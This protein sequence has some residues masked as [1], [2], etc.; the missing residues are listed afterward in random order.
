MDKSAI[1]NQVREFY[2]Q[3]GWQ[4]VSEGVYQN[5]RY[6]DLRPVSQEYIHKCHMRVKRFLAATGDFLLDAGSGPVQYPEYIT[7]SQDYRFRVCV[8]ISITALE[9][10]RQRLGVHGLYVVCDIAHLPF[11]SEAFDG[12]V[13]LHAIHHI[14]YE[15]QPDA[16]LNLFRVLQAGKS[17]VIVNAW[18][19]SSLMK[20]LKWL[21]KFMDRLSGITRRLFQPKT[22]QAALERTS[23]SLRS[24]KTQPTGTYAQ[25]YD[26]ETLLAEFARFQVPAEIYTWRSL[27]VR[28]LRAVI[29]PGLAGRGLLRLVY[30]L[31]EKYPGYFGRNGQYPLIVLRKPEQET[32]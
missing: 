28:F 17:A 5:A 1:K 12:I 13:S 19:Y 3:V 7:Y 29:H 11:K 14:P 24:P 6:E 23:G 16:Y 4:Q 20:R 10:A 22:Q 31:E 21:E 9:E 25:H 26:A 15:G 2:D 27:S 18:N 32:S 8:D 30:R